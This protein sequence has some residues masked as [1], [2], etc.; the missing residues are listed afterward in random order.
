MVALLCY[1]IINNSIMFR[2]LLLV[3]SRKV[4][5][6]SLNMKVDCLKQGHDSNFKNTVNNFKK[7]HDSDLNIAVD[8][9]KKS[10]FG[11]L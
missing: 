1:I 10:L 7:G 8:H 11:F 6:Q 9:L 2:Y 3:V 4:T 5:I